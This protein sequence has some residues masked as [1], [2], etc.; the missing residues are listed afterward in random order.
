MYAVMKKNESGGG[1]ILIAILRPYCYRIPN[2]TRVRII[3]AVQ[4]DIP[5]R[6]RERDGYTI[7][8]FILSIRATPGVWKSAREVLLPARLYI[9]R[10]GKFWKI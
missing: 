3:R 6:A 7:Y 10:D 4:I 5:P 2:V 8:L 1:P 9:P